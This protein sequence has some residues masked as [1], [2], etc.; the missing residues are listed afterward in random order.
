VKRLLAETTLFMLALACSPTF[1]LP[2]Q[3]RPGVPSGAAEPGVT[4]TR[5]GN[6]VFE[7]DIAAPEPGV[8]SRVVLKENIEI[9]GVK[10]AE[11]WL[12]FVHSFA[13]ST[14]HALLDAMPASAS[15]KKGKIIVE[16]GLR[17]SGSLNGAVSVTH[18]SGDESIDADTRLAIAKSAPFPALPDTFPNA[19]AQFRVT[20]A[21][22]H[23]HPIPPSVG[24]SQ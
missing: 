8:G 22:N 19:V 5:H 6:I 18:S 16:F 23:P 4:L 3:E 17:R 15:R 12:G 20:F 21:Y 2:Q 14:G 7:A 13:D 10:D 1:L 24:T 11:D 9:T